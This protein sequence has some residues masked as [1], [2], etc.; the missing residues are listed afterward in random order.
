MDALALAFL[1]FAPCTGEGPGL[2]LEGGL[3]D[4]AVWWFVQT[5]RKGEERIKKNKMLVL[6]FFF[7]F[8]CDYKKKRKGRRDDKGGP[9]SSRGTIV[10]KGPAGT[11]GPGRRLGG[12]IYGYLYSQVIA[13]GHLRQSLTNIFIKHRLVCLIPSAQR[14]PSLNNIPSRPQHA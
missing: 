9:T 8:S 6:V 14:G 4:M 2:G 1:P 11:A 3:R 5:K 12:S 13:S 7:F 10:A